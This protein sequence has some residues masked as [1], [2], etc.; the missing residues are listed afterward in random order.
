MT[1]MAATP[2]SRSSKATN[3]RRATSKQRR[4]QHVL[5]VSV[6]TSY[7]AR[8]RQSKMFGVLAKLLLV[9]VVG[10]GLYFGIRRGVARGCC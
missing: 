6:R 3:A 9:V 5:D 10:V 1:H 2:S 8:Q 7:A 4:H